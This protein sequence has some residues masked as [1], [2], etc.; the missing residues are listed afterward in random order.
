MCAYTAAQQTHSWRTCRTLRT[1]PPH[2]R[3][4]WKRER[5]HTNTHTHTQRGS[6]TQTSRHTHMHVHT[7][8]C[9]ARECGKGSQRS[10]RTPGATT[11]LCVRARLAGGARGNARA[12][13]HA[14]WTDC[15]TLSNITVC[16]SV[17]VS[18]VYRRASPAP[19]NV[20][21]GHDEHGCL[22]PLNPPCR[23]C[24]LNFPAT[25]AGGSEH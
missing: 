18:S 9:K 4:T 3:R 23:P 13:T 15:S 7:H 5:A 24:T 19:E 25:Q 21:A 1:C 20:P 2:R 17:C 10:R 22:P 11:A 12:H 8:V 6:T 14:T 16:G